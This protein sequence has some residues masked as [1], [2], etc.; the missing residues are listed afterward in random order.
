M[1][2]E[3]LKNMDDALS[4]ILLF[5]FEQGEI[6]GDEMEEIVA[7]ADM[8]NISQGDEG[9]FVANLL[10]KIRQRKSEGG[11]YVF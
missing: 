11:Y 5:L 2:E 1:N 8:T 9:E 10:E 3:M 7:E 6:S 4:A